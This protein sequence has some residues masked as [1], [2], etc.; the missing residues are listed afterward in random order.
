MPEKYLQS[1]LYQF[2]IKIIF[3][4]F[5]GVGVKLAIEMKRSNTKLSVFNICSSMV[6]GIGMAYTFSGTVQSMFQENYVPGIIAIIAMMSEK[7]GSFLL[8]R[9]KIDIL[10]IAIING[11]FSWISRTFKLN[12]MTLF[13]N[14]KTT[15]V[16]IG[17]LVTWFLYRDEFTWWFS[18]ILIG[19]GIVLL[20]AK[21]QLPFIIRKTVN[22]VINKYFG[23]KPSNK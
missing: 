10:V 6:V 22:G 19:I 13:E 14:I 8:Y 7:I 21:D 23:N 1:E 18:L 4:A 11:I 9:F 5:M 16:G 2:I 15:I 12:D 17:F 20:F 3:P